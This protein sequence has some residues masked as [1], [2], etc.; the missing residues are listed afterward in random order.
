MMPHC[1]EI[2]VRIYTSIAF[3]YSALPNAF[4]EKKDKMDGTE[5]VKHITNLAK[6]STMVLHMEGFCCTFIEFVS[7][8]IL[9]FMFVRFIRKTFKLHFDLN[10]FERIAS[11]RRGAW[12]SSTQQ[13]K[14]TEKNTK[15]C[16]NLKLWLLNY[17]SRYIFSHDFRNLQLE[18]FENAASIRCVRVCARKCVSARQC[19]KW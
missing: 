15:H 3:Q 12:G 19:V 1:D 13:Q 10:I 16:L 6:R 4:E 5:L 17:V 18:S 11:H 2:G 8:I 9:H 14:K 7:V